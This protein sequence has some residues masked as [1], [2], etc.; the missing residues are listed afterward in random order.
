MHGE[1][2]ALVPLSQSQELYDVLIA[3][4]VSATLVVVKNAGHGF[5]PAGG[6]I[7]PSRAEITR[8]IADFFYQH[9]R[10]A[11]VRSQDSFTESQLTVLEN[12]SAQLAAPQAEP[13]N[14]STSETARV[15][16]SQRF[17][18]ELTLRQ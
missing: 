14:T 12:P 3:A 16:V 18:T 6:R 17:A 9:I 4:H 11:D 15:T 1:K 7:S 5:A 10:Q 8:M 13:V 2:D